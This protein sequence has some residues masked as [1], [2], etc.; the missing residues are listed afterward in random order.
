MPNSRRSICVF[1]SSLPHHYRRLFCV[2]LAICISTC[3][4]SCFS[5]Q[6]HPDA[7][8]RHPSAILHHPSATLCQSSSWR[9][10]TSFQ[11]HPA[12]FRRHPASSWRFPSVIISSWRHPGVILALSWHSILALS[13]HS[14]LALPGRRHPVLRYPAVIPSSSISLKLSNTWIIYCLTVVYYV[15]HLMFHA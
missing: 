7:I 4:T 10:H 5:T 3:V 9:H 13:W 11:R 1:V 15:A 14:I 12:S 8:L 6:R 2:I